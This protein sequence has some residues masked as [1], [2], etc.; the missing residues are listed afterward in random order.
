M[1]Q[2]PLRLEKMEGLEFR[3]FLG[4]W[5]FRIQSASGFRVF[6][7]SECFWIPSVSGFRVFRMAGSEWLVRNGRGPKTVFHEKMEEKWIAQKS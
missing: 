5:K 2:R 3:M 4:P 1:G 7:D 6:L